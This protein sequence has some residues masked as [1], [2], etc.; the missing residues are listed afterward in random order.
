M[1]ES[2]FHFARP[3]YEQRYLPCLW[4]GVTSINVSCLV[5]KGAQSSQ[6]HFCFS[7]LAQ[8]VT[9]VCIELY[10]IQEESQYLIAVMALK[11]W[12]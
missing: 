2:I 12:L 10:R 5:T 9:V 11:G 6:N 8:L 1:F 7:V 3:A 4:E